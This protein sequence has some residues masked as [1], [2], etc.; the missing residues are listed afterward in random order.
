MNQPRSRS[1]YRAPISSDDA[2]AVVTDAVAPAETDRD[3]LAQLMLDAYRGSIDDEGETFEDACQAVD[4]ML[5]RCIRDHSFVLKRGGT[6]IA[7]S[8]VIELDGIHYIDPVAVAAPHKEAGLGRRMVETSL[9]SM[10][11]SGVTEVGA[12]ITDGNEPSE[13]LFAGLGATRCGPWPPADRPPPT[14]TRGR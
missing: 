8:L 11:A 5:E 4:H 12:T 10:A 3:G 2:H 1:E 13:R 14:D 7:M 6:P 9:A